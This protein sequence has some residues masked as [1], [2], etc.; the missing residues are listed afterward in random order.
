VL[1]KQYPAKSKS[2]T[3]SGRKPT[4]RDDRLI[5]LAFLQSPTSKPPTPYFSPSHFV[6]HSQLSIH[7]RYYCGFFTIN[8]SLDLLSLL[9]LSFAAL[10]ISAGF[11]PYWM[12][13]A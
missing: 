6:L 13:V 2:S 9:L 7:P 3:A 10:I 1:E 8:R 11:V 4:A 12:D 5:G